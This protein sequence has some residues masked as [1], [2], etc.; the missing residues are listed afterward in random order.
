MG[1]KDRCSYVRP[2]AYALAVLGGLVL[3]IA[4]FGGFEPAAIANN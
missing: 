1:Q 4:L 3:V 2:A